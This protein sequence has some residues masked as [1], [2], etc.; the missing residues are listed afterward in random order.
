MGE[1]KFDK[2]WVGRCKKETVEGTEYC[3]DHL[4][5][6]CR[7]CG[8]QAT[9]DCGETFQLV[10]GTPLCNKEECKIKHHPTHHRLTPKRWAEIYQTEIPATLMESAVKVEFDTFRSNLLK[11]PVRE[12]TEAIATK[13]EGQE[14]DGVAKVYGFCD[15]LVVHFS[16]GMSVRYKA[17]L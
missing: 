16:N 5:E 6:T 14:I 2:A 8:E 9:H 10:C 7:V 1:C 3:T 4:K 11:Q 17:D 15:V 12:L 13:M